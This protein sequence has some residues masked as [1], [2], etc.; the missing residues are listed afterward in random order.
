MLTSSVSLLALDPG[1][2]PNHLLLIDG[3]TKG[4][5]RARTR[6][7][8]RFPVRWEKKIESGIA[9]PQLPGWCCDRLEEGNIDAEQ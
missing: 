2:P 3:Q 5:F 6:A 1:V 7:V 9:P 4:F 8:N